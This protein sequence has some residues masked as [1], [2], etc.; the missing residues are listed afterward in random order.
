MKQDRGLWGQN[1]WERA[2][3]APAFTVTMSV[4][5]ENEKISYMSINRKLANKLCYGHI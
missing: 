4:N 3:G 1:N 2:R 5:R